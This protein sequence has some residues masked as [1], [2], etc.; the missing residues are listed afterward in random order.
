MALPDVVL[1][2]ID[3][4]NTKATKINNPVDQH[5]SSVAAHHLVLAAR[6]TC[7]RCRSVCLPATERPV[8]LYSTK[9]KVQSQLVFYRNMPNFF[10]ALVWQVARRRLAQTLLTTTIINNGEHRCETSFVGLFDGHIV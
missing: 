10:H 3:A 7:F 4:L 8:Q 9:N 6:N 1:G 2:D 5:A